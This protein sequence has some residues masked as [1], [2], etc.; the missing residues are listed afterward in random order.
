MTTPAPSRLGPLNDALNMKN[1]KN[2]ALS[3]PPQ[4]APIG[5]LEPV[6]EFILHNMS[7]RFECTCGPV[8]RN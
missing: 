3:G 8:Q 1:A 6:A 2:A 7:L 4:V 5:T